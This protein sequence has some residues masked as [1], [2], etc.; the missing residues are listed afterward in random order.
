MNEMEIFRMLFNTYFDRVYRSTFLIVQNEL[1]AKDATQ[2]AFIAAYKQL[3]RLKDLDKIYTC[4]IEP[5][6]KHA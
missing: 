3:D 1:I 5:G 2:E 6:H 4:S